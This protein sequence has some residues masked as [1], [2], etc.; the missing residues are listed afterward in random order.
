MKSTLLILFLGASAVSAQI[1]WDALT[2]VPANDIAMPTLRDWQQKV[3]EN[4][5][6]GGIAEARFSSWLELPFP[7][8]K[9]L[10]PGLRFFTVSWIERPSPGKEKEA[11]GLSGG[12][13]TLI[14]TADGKLAKEIYH[15]GNYDPYGDF[16]ATKKVSI[17]SPED[18][19]L[20]WDGFC[21]LHQK[22]W[23]DEPAVKISDTIW[24]LGDTTI[25]GVHYYYEVILDA[26]Q[27]V[28]FARLHADYSER[29]KSK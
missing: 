23:Q 18:A 3:V 16:L 22:D 5:A 21:D 27:I 24:H 25:D 9:K 11:I 4:Y 26:S 20:I 13:Y 10:F 12:E 8:L 6:K 1:R 28:T 2:P 29:S 7:P 14:C 15:Y 19:K 17:R